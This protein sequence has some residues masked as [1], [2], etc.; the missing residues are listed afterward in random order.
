MPISKPKHIAV[1]RHFYKCLFFT[2]FHVRVYITS[3]H[4]VFNCLIASYSSSALMLVGAFFAQSTVI[5]AAG[6]NENAVQFSCF[7][8]NPESR[9]SCK[10]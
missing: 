4:S 7:N 10:E 6:V 2:H 3:P 9:H 1:K 8:K 5:Y